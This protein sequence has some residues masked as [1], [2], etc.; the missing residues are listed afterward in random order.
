[1]G[2]VTIYLDPAI[3]KKMKQSAKSTNLSLSKWI[4]NIITEKISVQWP[5]EIKN[6]AGAWRDF[7]S[8]EDIRSSHGENVKREKL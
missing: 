8:I 2:Q 7:P 5:E 4:S 3:E 1:M 6:L